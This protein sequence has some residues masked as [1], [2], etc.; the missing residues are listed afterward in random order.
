MEENNGINIA[1]KVLGERISELE[2]EVRY[3]R[4]LKEEAIKKM[5]DLKTVNAN[6]AS[7]LENVQHYI[8]KM[9]E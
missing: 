4:L 9:E 7:K 2:S 6:L 1:F 5:E 3:E 8:E